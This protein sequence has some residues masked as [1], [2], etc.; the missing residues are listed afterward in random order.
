MA[1]LE[2][3]PQSGGPRTGWDLPDALPPAGTHLAVCIGIKDSFDVERPTFD[4]PSI[5]ETVNLCRFAF[6]LVGQDGIAYVLQTKELKISAHEKANLFIMLM[7]WLGHPP[8]IG[9]DTLDMVGRGA[10]LTIGHETSQKT[11]RTY[12]AI[13]SIAPVLPVVANQVPDPGLFKLP[14]PEPTSPDPLEA[15]Q[16][17]PPEAQKLDAPEPTPT[18]STQTIFSEIKP[19]AP[20]TPEVEF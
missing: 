10:Q 6:G 4:D 19:A 8:T 17:C 5:S 15:T 3:P 12:P 1:I 13:S 16:P 9:M 18:P 2:Q 20:E 14:T 11:G 7:Q